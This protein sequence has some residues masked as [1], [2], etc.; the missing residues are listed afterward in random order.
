MAARF[1]VPVRSAGP[2]AILRL[3]RALDPAVRDVFG[4][5]DDRFATA[6]VGLHRAFWEARLR[7]EQA[8]AA[9]FTLTGGTFLQPGLFDRRAVGQHESARQAR[10]D[11]LADSER[12]VAEIGR[13]FAATM[14]TS[15]VVLV[16]VP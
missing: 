1:A 2:D 5:D 14:K 10:A 4:D 16:L 7:R 11:W 3:W 12:R 15:S 13:A 8:V 6:A 9:R